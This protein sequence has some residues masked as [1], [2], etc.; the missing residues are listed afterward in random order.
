MENELVQ[1]YIVNSELNM[2]TGKIAGQ[3]AH[4]ATMIAVDAI[5]NPYTDI[6]ETDYTEEYLRFH[7]WYKQG[8]GQ[9][10]IILR[11]K[12]CKLEELV[13]LGFYHIRDNG[14]TEIEMD[15]L[16]CVGLGVMTREEAQPYIKRLQLL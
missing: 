12:Q 14:L 4:V 2:S 5:K 11:A 10:K 13:S 6:F 16:T 9:K 15:S 3:I 8:K 1:Y 7:E